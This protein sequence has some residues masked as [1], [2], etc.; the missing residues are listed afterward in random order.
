MIL[1]LGQI[2]DTGIARVLLNGRDLGIVWTKPFRVDISGAVKPGLNQLRVEVV[3]SWRNRLIGDQR[4]PANQRQT[5]TNIAVTPNW[6]PTPSG[7][8]GP[9]RILRQTEADH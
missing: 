3:N 8:L 2:E 4:L 6:K 5:A 7:L 1:D 9:V